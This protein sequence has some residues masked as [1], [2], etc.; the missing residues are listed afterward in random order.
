MRKTDY[1]RYQYIKVEKDNGLITLTLNR[2]ESLNAI[3]PTMHHELET[4]WIDVSEDEEVN[5]I[6]LTGSGRGFCASL[7]T[8]AGACG[9]QAG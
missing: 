7:E 1:S 6:L 2:P 8:T 5:A 9:K 3:I 4:I